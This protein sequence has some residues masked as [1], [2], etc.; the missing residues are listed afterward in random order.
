M[1][2]RAEIRG[3]QLSEVDQLASDQQSE[4]GKEAKYRSLSYRVR[5]PEE[6]AQHKADVDKRAERIMALKAQGLNNTIIAAR[7]GLSP[8]HVGKIARE[9]SQK[10]Q[11]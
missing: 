3:R 1:T 9:H 8:G 11:N 4:M 2:R 10:A 5:T 7:M 6:R